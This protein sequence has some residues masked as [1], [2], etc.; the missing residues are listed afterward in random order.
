MDTEI[1]RNNFWFLTI[2]VSWFNVPNC[3][4]KWKCCSLAEIIIWCKHLIFLIHTGKVSE[5]AA[6]VNVHI[7][8][9][10]TDD[11][12]QN[13]NST[14]IWINKLQIYL[15]WLL[16]LWPVLSKITVNGHCIH[17]MDERFFIEVEQ[18]SFPV[19]FTTP[20]S[21]WIITKCILMTLGVE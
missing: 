16:T 13:K 10:V 12:Q 18:H 14:L 1:N 21:P 9:Q 4:R 11:C 7:C 17:R 15:I 8:P 5:E 2:V 3:D 19:F 6:L 20:I